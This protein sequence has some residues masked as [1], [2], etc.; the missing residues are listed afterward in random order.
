MENTKTL[1]KGSISIKLV[2]DVFDNDLAEPTIQ[3][4]IR[5][6]TDLPHKQKHCLQFSFHYPGLAKRDHI[7]FQLDQNSYGDDERA[8]LID[9]IQLQPCDFI[10]K[11]FFIYTRDPVY[12]SLSFDFAIRF[13]A[14]LPSSLKIDTILHETII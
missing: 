3:V 5:V 2:A 1:Y 4:P 14:S 11:G 10:L 12:E 7:L 9:V 6:F 13:K 8:F